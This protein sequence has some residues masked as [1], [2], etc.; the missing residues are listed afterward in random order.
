VIDASQRF[1]ETLAGRAQVALL[2]Q[3]V[4]DRI[5]RAGTEFIAV[6]SQLLDEPEAEDTAFRGMMKNVKSYQIPEDIL[7]TIRWVHDDVTAMNFRDILAL[8]QE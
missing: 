6:S 1:A 5:E 2:F 3:T 4:K 8:G 7:T